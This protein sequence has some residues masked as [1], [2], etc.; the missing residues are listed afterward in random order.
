[1]ARRWPKDLAW[2]EVVLEVEDSR[3]GECGRRMHVRDHRQ[4]RIY[5][6]E[7]P[8]HL[9]CKLMQCTEPTCPNHHRTFGPLREFTLT[10]PRW[11]IGWDVF[12]WLGHRRFARH[13]SVPQL[14]AELLDSHDIA[15]SEDAIE[16]HLQ[17][18]QWMLAARQQDLTLLKKEY[19]KTRHVMLSI[20]GLQPEKGHET[21]YVVRELCQ[22]RVWFAQAL[23]SSATDEIRP[24][25]VQPRDWA[26]R[27]E[28]PV[29][30]WM[31]DKQDAFVT[32]IA[33]E[34]PG[35]P[36]RYCA[37]HFLRD[38]AKPMLELDS[39]AKVQMRSKIRG[40]RAIEREVLQLRAVDP[41]ERNAERERLPSVLESDTPGLDVVLDY[42]A[43]VRG[44]INDSQGG[45]LRPPGLR[46][47]QALGEVQ[48]S[49]S[50]NVRL[51]KGGTQNRCLSAW[52][53]ASRKEEASC[54]NRRNKWKCMSKRFVKSMRH[55]T[56]LRTAG[57]N[58]SESMRPSE[59]VCWTRTTRFADRWGA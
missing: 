15:L 38:L 50:R 13:W 7:G 55:W 27:L 25:L 19:Q 58:E 48:Q 12:C 32:T 16:D 39:H 2:T 37:N 56:P 9:V 35:V 17:R 41:A 31:S 3:C 20:D 33:R 49:L 42:C 24:L 45:P 51:K 23:L 44:I 54:W 46:M 11:L 10:M 30:L 40:L 18:Y 59:A 8:L 29:R 21:L 36:H 6:L 28:R 5:S 53:D 34:F 1:M 26:K 43:A 22:Q 57:R 52:Q 47:S 14:R 4:H